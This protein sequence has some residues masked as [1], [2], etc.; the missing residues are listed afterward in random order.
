M[1]IA[2][3]NDDVAPPHHFDDAEN[4]D[5]PVPE[6][7]E[8]LE[9]DG[10]EE[11][12]EEPATLLSFDDASNSLASLWRTRNEGLRDDF[13]RDM[14]PTLLHVILDAVEFH[15]FSVMNLVALSLDVSLVSGLALLEDGVFLGP[16]TTNCLEEN[17]LESAVSL[18]SHIHSR[19]YADTLKKKRRLPQS[20]GYPL[21]VAV[22]AQV[23]ANSS[24]SSWKQVTET[25]KQWLKAS[26][27]MTGD[28]VDAGLALFGLLRLKKRMHLEG[29]TSATLLQT[30][31]DGGAR[32]VQ[33]FCCCFNL[34][35]LPSI[36]FAHLLVLAPLYKRRSIQILGPACGLQ[37]YTLCMHVVDVLLECD[38]DAADEVYAG[39]IKL[40]D[41]FL[42]TT[43]VTHE[44]TAIRFMH[45]LKT[46]SKTS[47]N[48]PE[49]RKELISPNYPLRIHVTMF[50]AREQP[51]A[52]W[53]VAA[54][55][56]HC[57]FLDDG[58][59][60]NA[61]EQCLVYLR[62][63]GMLLLDGNKDS[64]S[65]QKKYTDLNNL[66]SCM[67][68]QLGMDVLCRYFQELVEEVTLNGAYMT[69]DEQYYL[70]LASQRTL[71]LMLRDKVKDP[72][73]VMDLFF[74]IFPD[75]DYSFGNKITWAQAFLQRRNPIPQSLLLEGD[76]IDLVSFGQRA[77]LM[78]QQ[79]QQALEQQQEAELLQQQEVEQQQI[80]EQAE[81][82]ARLLL[83]QQAEAELIQIEDE[84]APEPLPFE[85][86]V[87]QEPQQIQDEVAPE[88]IQIQ[89]EA[90]EILESEEEEPMDDVD[91]EVVE[92]EEMEEDA[93]RHIEI[94]DGESDEDVIQVLDDNQNVVQVIEDEEEEEDANEVI[95]DDVEDDY[96]R[97]DDQMEEE[98][99]DE[100]EGYGA[101]SDEEDMVEGDDIV[102]EEE[103]EVVEIIDSEDDDATEDFTELHQ[104]HL[105]Q[106]DLGDESEP[107]EMLDDDDAAHEA[108]VEH[109]DEDE[110][111][112]DGDETADEGHVA[113]PSLFLQDRQAQINHDDDDDCGSQVDDRQEHVL[114]ETKESKAEKELLEKGY[115]A[116]IPNG[117][118]VP[119][120][121]EKG[122]E[123]DTAGLTEEEVSEQEAPAT[124]EED[125]VEEESKRDTH[126]ESTIAAVAA[127]AA[128]AN[129]PGSYSDDMDDADER[130]EEEHG[131]ESMSEL[132]ENVG[133][134]RR[135]EPERVI[136]PAKSYSILDAYAKHAQT[137]TRE[138][139]F[140]TD[141]SRNASEDNYYTPAPRLSVGGGSQVDP[142]S[143][144]D[145]TGVNEDMEDHVDEPNVVD[146]AVAPNEDR[147]EEDEQPEVTKNSTLETNEPE[148]EEVEESQE[149][150]S[151]ESEEYIE[152]VDSPAVVD[153]AGVEIK[154][155]RPSF[156]RNASTTVQVGDMSA[157]ELDEDVVDKVPTRHPLQRP[158][159]MRN[160]STAV[161]VGDMSAGGLDEDVVDKVPERR[162]PVMNRNESTAV[163]HGELP[164]GDEVEYLENHLGQIPPAQRPSLDR[165]ASTLV[166][167]G[168]LSTD[169][170][171]DDLAA[172]APANKAAFENDEVVNR[173]PEMEEIQKM[174]LLDRNVSTVA[175]LDS[176]R[177]DEAID[178]DDG[179]AKEDE[180][181]GMP[182][183]DA[184]IKSDVSATKDDEDDTI[185]DADQ[186][187]EDQIDDL[188]QPNEGGVD[189][190]EEIEEESIAPDDAEESPDEAVE[191]IATHD[192][193]VDH[194]IEK[195]ESPQEEPVD[196][197]SP[198]EPVEPI[199]T[200]TRSHDHDAENKEE[201]D[202]AP[203][204]E[205]VDEVSPEEPVEPIATHTR[206]HDTDAESEE[207]E[208]E[209]PPEEP[210]EPIA[211]H[212]RSR[213]DGAD[214]E[215][216]E[217]EDEAPP[218]DPAD[219]VSPEEPVEPIATHTR[220]HDDGADTESEEEEDEAPA[221][222]SLD[223]G[224]PGEP[225]AAQAQAKDRD[226]EAESEKEVSGDDELPVK[227][228]I[229][230]KKVKSSSS[231]SSR[232]RESIDSLGTMAGRTV[233]IGRASVDSSM[234]SS[235]RS[236]RPRRGTRSAAVLPK[237]RED[238]I[239]NERL[240]ESEE[241][242]EEVALKESPPKKKRGRP[243]KNKEEIEP[244]RSPP[245]IRR[246]ARSKKDDDC[247]SSAKVK[248][249][250]AAKQEEEEVEPRA[251]SSKRKRSRVA[252]KEE[253]DVESQES[254][255]KKRRG[256][257]PKNK[258]EVEPIISP[259]KTRRG[260]RSKKDDD[261]ASSTR[262]KRVRA[263]KQEE[264]DVESHASP[265]RRK[266]SRV[267]KKEEEGVESD[268]SPPKKSRAPK[269]DE[270]ETE[271]SPP[272]K[273]RLGRARKTEE[274]PEEKV[275]TTAKGR[276]RGSRKK[277]VDDSSVDE[278]SVSTRRSART[279]KAPT[280]YN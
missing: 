13:L 43:S 8:P 35:V 209:A 162:R 123:P 24:Q 122:Y 211:T 225:I 52:A 64:P 32:Y 259:P 101:R 247:A 235:T 156:D 184:D 250:R 193:D 33:S 238:S 131:A 98:N 217:E 86:A 37:K 135:H 5:D 245:K 117:E 175:V 227:K 159:F 15:E 89:N 68:T 212:T 142:S 22:V 69:Q 234:A 164:E 224:P 177:E 57:A 40:L 28:V 26:F 140:A 102:S 82:R 153:T 202:E 96:D 218:E 55:M 155:Q 231:R 103:V 137:S 132:E 107:V 157:D 88:P 99:M 125:N 229:R 59:K 151:Q 147:A 12:E 179:E 181:A 54:K 51:S 275:D 42:R 90:V 36:G 187:I 146:D 71:L 145:H 76:H 108:D 176:F 104:Q 81:Q 154:I 25:T 183:Y 195:E 239:S 273:K 261:S 119:P 163:Q 127:R 188:E 233:T 207:E 152:I 23:I 87:V 41:A 31:A 50:L 255:P 260:A 80:V 39:T 172:I 236:L 219:E 136:P 2:A 148:S 16:T 93:G 78:E 254:P 222:E 95:E 272:K 1:M 97:D 113:Q 189:P 171:E 79:Q 223:E 94:L 180:D 252:K 249:G 65:Y 206:S 230:G 280:K 6:E 242:E 84:A 14:A 237:I 114:E 62:S 166:H 198:E 262:V 138:E 158:S 258:E 60:R 47:I 191:P 185:S 18:F 115:D 38:R 265:A 226:V 10:E 110:T 75:A 100:D 205:P 215:S 246:G 203:A 264:Q 256:R 126:V 17:D 61:W 169:D 53:N 120:E 279:R 194:E 276:K 73:R 29:L 197:V 45:E 121:V 133:H 216:E 92:E 173:V 278:A 34:C 139:E 27:H 11:E 161:Q 134:V 274:E 204:E 19:L 130:T 214:T 67:G 112:F 58:A 106:G 267:A 174:P 220:S 63:I 192:H 149:Q 271:K 270:V 74:E 213:D 244:T 128:Q 277:A 66:V 118:A 141:L 263:V 232:A 186:M 210:V 208:D 201:E 150:T 129:L 248:R 240:S 190:A 221:E 199:A 49:G 109:V 143:P 111:E 253:Q 200:H 91:E 3:N 44:D 20:R 241:E 228:G 7:A 168:D 46:G 4:E 116:D 144:V 77:V 21:L 182:S 178:T 196:E 72:N 165:G 48:A 170:L 83:Q 30:L 124:E 257:P 268:E 70:V 160:E 269:K 167:V 105:D 56:E 251:S 243:P 266:R 85:E 9:D